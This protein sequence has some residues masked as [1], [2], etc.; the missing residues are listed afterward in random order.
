MIAL[1]V[2]EH[3][4]CVSEIRRVLRPGGRLVVTM[5]TLG[6][7]RLWDLLI[8]ARLIQPRFTPHVNFWRV[9]DLP[10]RCVAERPCLLGLNQFGVLV[11]EPAVAA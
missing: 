8:A 7:E 11:N 9:R 4:D 2:L 1:E 5:P 3:V 10:L 6:L